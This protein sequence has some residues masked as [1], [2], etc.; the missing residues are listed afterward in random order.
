MYIHYMRG[1]NSDQNPN[2]IWQ[3]NKVSISLESSEQII[4]PIS[5]NPQVS[6]LSNLAEH[7]RKHISLV[8]TC[9]LRWSASLHDDVGRLRTT[10]T[11]FLLRQL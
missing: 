10:K 8:L 4:D 3:I 6:Y 2:F 1:Y 7:E 5:S 9:I 11:P